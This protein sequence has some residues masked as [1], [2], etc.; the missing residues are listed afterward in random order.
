MDRQLQIKN[1]V[2]CAEWQGTPPHP[3]CTDEMKADGWEFVDVSNRP[4]ARVGCTYKDGQFI[5]APPPP[6]YGVQV[7]PRDFLYLFTAA[8]RKAIRHAAKTDPDVDDFMFIVSVPQPVFLKKENTVAGL[9]LLVARGLITED[10]KFRIMNNLPPGF[11][12]DGD[13]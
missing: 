6:D 10:D 11:D 4:D 3:L 2:V 5:P 8:Q 7:A 9:D 12:I 13:E 1:G